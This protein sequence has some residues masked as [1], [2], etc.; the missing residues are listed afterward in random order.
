MPETVDRFLKGIKMKKVL[1]TKKRWTAFLLALL[2]AVTACM[3]A[4]DTFLL[5]AGEDEKAVSG[6][7]DMDRGPVTKVL[8]MKVEEE[9]EPS[10]VSGNQPEYVYDSAENTGAPVEEEIAQ[11]KTEVSD[12]EETPDEVL[13]QK[14]TITYDLNGGAGTVPEPVEAEDGALI[15]LP[16]GDGISF[17]DHRL[18]G[19]AKTRDANS[20]AEGMKA[21]VYSLGGTYEVTGDQTLYAVWARV[22]GSQRGRITIAL[23]KDGTIPDEPSIQDAEY[24]FLAGGMGADNRERGSIAADNILEY[25]SPAHTVSGTEHVAAALKNAFY[26]YTEQVN[27]DSNSMFWNP[28]TQEIVWY[29][30]KYQASDQIWHIDGV[31]REKGR[32]NLTYDRN[33]A[34]GGLAPDS[35]QYAKGWEAEVEENSDSPLTKDGYDFAGWSTEADGTGTTYRAGDRILM[36]GHVTLFAKWLPKNNTKYAVEYYLEDLTEGSYTLK[37]REERTGTTGMYVGAEKRDYEGFTWDGSIAGTAEKGIVAAD[38]SLVLRLYYTRNSYVVSYEYEKDVPEGAGALPA[39]AV[40]RYGATVTVAEAASAPEGYVFLGWDAAP[41]FEMGAEDVTIKGSFSPERNLPY[42]I[43]YFYDNTEDENSRITGSDGVFGTAFFDAGNVERQITH[44]GKHYVLRTADPIV[45]PGGGI[46]TMRADENV[47]RIYYVLDENGPHSVPDLVPDEEEYHVTYLAN[48]GSDKMGKTERKSSEIYAA[49]DFVHI[50]DGSLFTKQ[51]AVFAG[52]RHQDGTF[53]RAE[54]LTENSVCRMVDGGVIFTT[55]W[56]MMRISKELAKDSQNKTFQ[57]G[58]RINFEIRVTNDGDIPLENVTVTDALEDAVIDTVDGE[59][60]STKGN[61]TVIDSIEPGKTAV[62]AAHCIVSESVIGNDNFANRAKAVNGTM[63]REAKTGTIPVAGIDRQLDVNKTVINQEEAT[64]TDVAGNKVFALGDTVRFDIAVRNAGNKSLFGITV[65][66]ELEGAKIVPGDGY[67][68][69]PWDDSKAIILCLTPDSDPVV[70]KA[71]YTIEEKDIG[72]TELRNTAAAKAVDG[73]ADSGTT[74]DPIPVDVERPAFSVKKV[75]VPEQMEDG[76]GKTEYKVGETVNYRITVEN[77]GN[78]N[79]SDIEVTDQLNGAAGTVVFAEKDGVDIEG[80]TATVRNL[81]TGADIELNCSYEILRDDAGKSITNTALVE[82]KRAADG[83]PAPESRRSE[84]T[85][86]VA[87]E[88]SYTL[89]V[90]Y[91]YADGTAASDAY[92][93]Q[94]LAGETYAVYSP[95]LE[96]Y[97]SNPAAV[98]GIMPADHVVIT[99]R[100]SASAQ[101]P[102][103]G[104]GRGGETSA[105]PAVSDEQDVPAEPEA[106]V[107]LPTPVPAGVVQAVI[108]A[109]LTPIGDEEVPLEG[110]FIKVDDDGNVMVT[111]IN[112][113]EVPLAGGII[114]DH[115]CCML[116]FL[117]MLAALVIYTWYTFSMKRHQKKLALLQ[118]QLAEEML[119][120]RLGISDNRKAGR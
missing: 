30:I 80:N 13:E 7:A 6:Q 108:E 95:V 20:V 17:A 50:N 41:E 113:E 81:E 28:E 83:G 2:L 43:Q 91:I 16:E 69:H 109:E 53:Y 120:R 62:V 73:T 54:E 68:V 66:E 57:L 93:G 56:R 46:V 118:D 116:H 105:Q 5:A 78:V 3:N 37:D 79:L 72:E 64:G 98:T 38:G 1:M 110:A 39:E 106:T 101:A 117:F 89:T 32:V 44:G 99:V 18:I 84:A 58:D 21:T 119:K 42:V 4:S 65:E 45:M 115:K 55:Q 70:V 75:L 40:Y 36:T 107:I 35:R 49:G 9:D 15:S 10:T 24:Y 26:D 87:V 104:G 60:V 112:V 94:Y 22:G 88:D 92:T 111:P 25:F 77:T 85:E 82:G 103:G 76:T 19:W 67:I 71:E 31:V 96:G 12:V 33:G 8:R 11:E 29:V 48:G 86:P 114:D 34:T 74:P 51:D 52:W 23:R 63:S 61:E 97:N 100:Y 90:Q 27:R 59:P 102:S 14:Y 47:V